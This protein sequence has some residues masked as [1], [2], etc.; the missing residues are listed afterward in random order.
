MAFLLQVN[1]GTLNG[2]EQQQYLSQESTIIQYLLEMIRDPQSYVMLFML[3]M[4]NS[5]GLP[6]G[7]FTDWKYSVQAKI[8]SVLQR[9]QLVGTGRFT[10]ALSE[11]DYA[12]LISR[13]QHLAKFIPAMSVLRKDMK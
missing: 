3:V 4:L 12:L 9:Y 5:I 7:S 1:R 8:L 13:L 10:R 6:R 11:T 2:S